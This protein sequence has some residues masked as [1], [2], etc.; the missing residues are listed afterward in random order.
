MA[1]PLITPTT[2]LNDSALS[3]VS[4]AIPLIKSVDKAVI[5]SLECIG[6]ACIVLR[7]KLVLLPS[8]WWLNSA[9]SVT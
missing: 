9:A 1:P 3:R 4:E 8:K 5:S 6:I 2:D 7:V